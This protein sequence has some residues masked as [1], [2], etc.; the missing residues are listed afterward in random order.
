MTLR[1]FHYNLWPNAQ[2]ARIC[3]LEQGEAHELVTVDMSAKAHREPA[4]LALNPQGEPPVLI[5]T[6][7]PRGELKVW[8]YLAV[9][10][11]LQERQLRTGG[12]GPR[13]FPSDPATIP[14][15]DQW[16]AWSQVHFTPVMERLLLAGRILPTADRDVADMRPALRRFRQGL[17]ILNDNLPATGAAFINRTSFS[18]TGVFSA[19]D[20]TIGATLTL[21][22][23]IPQTELR[24]NDFPN[25]LSYVQGLEA[26]PSFRTAFGGI[27][28]PPG[29][30]P[31]LSSHC[32]V[33]AR[34][35]MSRGT[36]LPKLGYFRSR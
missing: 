29:P 27:T 32:S 13:L 5:D 30:T 19:A 2:A 10:R 34:D 17:R 14:P 21:A 18:P 7:G 1:L 25:V 12:S 15:T 28:L 20:I 6:A 35:A 16:A 33:A 31:R 9:G 36:R 22:R 3:L 8:E 4:F 11:Y 26:R 23:L 24:L